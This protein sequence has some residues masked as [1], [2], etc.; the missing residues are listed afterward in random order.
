MTSNNGSIPHV[1][2]VPVLEIQLA[3]DMLA[4]IVNHN[5]P[6]GFFASQD[7][8]SREEM[9]AALD[10]LCWVLGHDNHAFKDNIQKVARYLEDK[11]Y[12]FHIDPNNFGN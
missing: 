4:G 12:D 7:P 9:S 2:P 3:H 11:G 8:V 5:E 6:P 1:L 10:V